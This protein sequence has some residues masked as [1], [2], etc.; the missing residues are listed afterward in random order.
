MAGDG[1]QFREPALKENLNGVQS[2]EINV[3]GREMDI[4]RRLSEIF[5][6]FFFSPSSFFS[7][8]HQRRAINLPPFETITTGNDLLYF[9]SSWIIR[10]RR[11][12]SLTNVTLARIKRTSL[13][14]RTMFIFESNFLKNSLTAP[15]SLDAK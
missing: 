8:R 1:K 4:Y 9:K 12:V 7:S 3:S 11:D 5:L 6:F 14:Y 10:R 2:R 15:S 13:T